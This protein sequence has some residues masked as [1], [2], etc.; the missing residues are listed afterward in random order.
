MNIIN[1]FGGRSLTFIILLCNFSLS[2]FR[3]QWL[4][5]DR[6]S[7]F[8]LFVLLLFKFFGFYLF[9]QFYLQLLFLWKK[10]WIVIGATRY[11]LISTK[12]INCWL[13][14]MTHLYSSWGFAELRE[15]Y[16][17]LE[18]QLIECRLII[19][20]FSYLFFWLINSFTACFL[21]QIDDRLIVLLVFY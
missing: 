4:S 19:F 17:E 20:N 18:D 8:F 7:D 13:F 3:P 2:S 14:S 5:S 12:L 1:R 16:I 9:Q 15:G 11:C 10:I 21:L 6:R